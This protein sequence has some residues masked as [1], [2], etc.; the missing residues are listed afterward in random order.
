MQTTTLTTTCPGCGTT[1]HAVS[2]LLGAAMPC[3]GA[4]AVCRQ[5]GTVAVITSDAG[6]MRRM[7]P[8]EFRALSPVERGGLLHLARQIQWQMASRN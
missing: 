8:E 3:V 5:C 2:N 1:H 7:P 4:A 6:D